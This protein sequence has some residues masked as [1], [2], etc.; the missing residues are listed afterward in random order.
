MKFKKG[1]KEAKTYMAKLRAKKGKKTVKKVGAT[2]K[3]TGI[4]AKKQYNKDVDAYKYFVVNNGKV[5][6]GFEFKSDANDMAQDFHPKAKVLTK[7]Q[8]KQQGIKNPSEQWKY[9]LNGYSKKVGATLIIEGN[10]TRKTKPT[11]VIKRVRS[12]AGTFK[13]FSD[14][15]NGLFDTTV[16]KDLDSLKKEYLKLA[17]KY[18]PDKGGTTAQFQELE[19]EYRKY[20]DALIKGSSLNAEQ[21]ANEIQLDEAL[22]QAVNAIASLSGINIELAGKWLWVSGNTYPIR[23][24][25]KA[26]GFMFAPVKKMWYYKGT[27]SAGRGK[28]S[29]EEI[30]N[31]YGSTKIEPKPKQQ[32]NGIGKI[33]TTQK[34]KLKAALKKVAKALDKRAI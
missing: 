4:R 19:A 33:S 6:A 3:T 30:R 31:K 25:L 22:M 16:I 15:I 24:E 17:N 8:L 11:R 12:G 18:H 9:K 26:A 5:E 2:K 20:R 23:N 7:L 27:E 28:Y 13:S 21:K 34:S 32:I 1:S 10:E 14:A 29:M